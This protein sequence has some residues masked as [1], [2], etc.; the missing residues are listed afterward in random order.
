MN[1]LQYKR[2]SN[3]TDAEAVWK[4]LSPNKSLYDVWEFRFT[5]YKYFNYP[6]YFYT[7]FKGDEP[8]GLLPLMFNTDKQSLDFFAGFGYMEDNRVFLK[9]SDISI[10]QKLIDMIDL[11]ANLE[12]M[13]PDMSTIVGAEV[14]DYNYFIELKEL[15]TYEDFINKY[16]SS[17]GRRNL[18]SQMRKLSEYNFSLSYDNVDDLD[19][20]ERWNRLRFG[21][22]SSFAERPYWN[23]F[24]KEIAREFPSKIITLSLNREKVGVGFVLFHN[25][26]C[27][28][29][30]SGYNPELKNIGKYLTLLKIQAAIDE[31]CSIYD[32]GGSGAF[33]WKEDFNLLKKHLYTLKK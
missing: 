28:G 14:H 21:E 29:I 11:P 23:E 3:L 31:G 22:T 5:Y 10:T 26:I 17:D 13:H 20:L 19:I 18:L 2:I 4:T 24:F 27:Y 25:G 12:Y 9:E 16:L 32:A 33:G 30:N 8:V 15:K 6:L 1:D 7:A